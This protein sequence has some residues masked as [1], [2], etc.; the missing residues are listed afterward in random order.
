MS[1]EPST[2]KVLILYP[3]GINSVINKNIGAG[4]RVGLLAEFLDDNGY[5]V[6]VVSA[7]LKSQCKTIGNIRFV[8]VRFPSNI[9]LTILY[10]TAIIVSKLLKTPSLQAVAYYFFH[11]I[12]KSFVQTINNY[13]SECSSVLLEYPFWHSII[14]VK[15]V[16]LT[17]HDVL[18]ESWTR[19]GVKI[20]NRFLKQRLFKQEIMALS[21]C[22]RPVVVSEDDKAHF[23]GHGIDDLK[24]IVNPIKLPESPEGLL[25]QTTIQTS[26]SN[27]K[28][29]SA[30]FVGSGWYPNIAA[31][32]SIAHEIAFKCPSVKFY[33][34]GECCRN[35]ST[36]LPNVE[37]LGSVSSEELCRLYKIATYSLVPVLW[38]TGTSL[39][40]VEAL[41]YGKVIISTQVGI[42]GIAFEHMVHGVICDDISMYSQIINKLEGDVL[43]RNTLSS[44]AKLFAKQYD[45][46]LVFEG[47]LSILNEMRK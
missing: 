30:I 34:V 14:D 18:Y 33:I 47:Y 40:T 16:I 35:I 27:K 6:T 25:R 23:A 45:Y 32:K 21:G 1:G 20:V 22:F 39:K 10:A 41:A 9:L 15:R 7:G 12:D 19:S 31:A 43:I 8:Q 17:D 37:C 13:V 38:G 29:S 42:R 44:N 2:N 36:V 3:W 46:R 4:L 5:T 28:E 24:V 11:R 26:S